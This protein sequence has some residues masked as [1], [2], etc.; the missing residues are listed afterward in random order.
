MGAYTR[1]RRFPQTPEMG[2]GLA[3]ALVRN[4]CNALHIRD[5]QQSWTIWERSQAA[6]TAEPF[7]QFLHSFFI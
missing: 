4:S 5:G 7:L 3:G 6:Y 1:K 2:T